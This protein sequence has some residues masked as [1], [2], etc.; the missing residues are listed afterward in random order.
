MSGQNKP[1]DRGGPML[2]AAKLWRRTSGKGTDYLAGRLGGV[3]VL[4]MENR[5]RQGDDDATH[6]LMFAEA[7]P[8]TGGG[9]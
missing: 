1:R 3:K 2:T 9:Q 5:D 8:R 4:V 7:S 6:L